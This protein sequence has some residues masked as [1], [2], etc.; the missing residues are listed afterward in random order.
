MI[1][2][3]DDMGL[4]GYKH[5]R[6]GRPSQTAGSYKNKANSEEAPQKGRRKRRRRR[7]KVENMHDMPEFIPVTCLRLL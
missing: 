3:R 6:S 5:G 1:D 7:K 4:Y 2:E